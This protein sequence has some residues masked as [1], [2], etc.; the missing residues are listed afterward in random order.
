L[1]VH[2]VLERSRAKEL[3]VYLESTIEGVSMY[4]RVGFKRV[5]GFEMEIPSHDDPAGVAVYAEVCLLRKPG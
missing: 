1:L 5:G 2:E 3:P 4:K